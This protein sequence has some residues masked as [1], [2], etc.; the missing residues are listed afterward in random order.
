MKDLFGLGKCLFSTNTLIYVDLS[1]NV[2][3]DCLKT[4]LY[5]RCGIAV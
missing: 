5:V 2:E 1:I 4:V 3:Q